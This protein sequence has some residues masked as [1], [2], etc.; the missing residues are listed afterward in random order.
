M[1][2]CEA[3][4]YYGASGVSERGLRALWKSRVMLAVTDAA[5]DKLLAQPVQSPA[6]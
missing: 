5:W 6:S 4:S 3:L 1:E 2:D